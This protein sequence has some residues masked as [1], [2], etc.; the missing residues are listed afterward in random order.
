MK[1]LLLCCLVLFCFKSSL[2][3]Q[4]LSFEYDNA[5]NQTIR[6]WICINCP[7]IRAVKK[8][9]LISAATSKDSVTNKVPVNT[10]SGR[11]L[12]AYPN[13]VTEV[14]NVKWS[15]GDQSYVT[16]IDVFSMTGVRIYHRNYG[17]GQ[18]ET[19]IS[20]SGLG[21]GSYVVRVLYSDNKQEV[22]KIIKQ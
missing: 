17:P 14:L 1:K 11:K 10:E 13:P 16:S 15:A 8:D 21:P 19:S 6:R 5:G 18:G 3:A 2:F 7:V 9:G 4:E 20:F 22:L 12:T